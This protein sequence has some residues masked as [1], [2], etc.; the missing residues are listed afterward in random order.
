MT[1]PV[2]TF[3]EPTA[4]PTSAKSALTQYKDQ[5]A[6][7]P[8]SRFIGSI[9]WYSIAGGQERGVDG[10]R[11]TVPVRVHQDLLAAW[12]EEFEIDPAYLPPRIKKIDAFRA[13]T[14]QVRKREYPL[15]EGGTRFGQLRIDEVK[16]DPEQVIRHVVRI[17]RDERK[18]QLSMDH[19]ATI[20]FIRGGRTARGKRH[21]GD[22]VKWAIL[23]RVQGEDRVQVEALLDEFDERYEDLSNHLH[24]PALRGIVRNF[25][26]TSLNAISMKTSGGLYFVHKNKWPQVA[27]IQQL[28]RRLGPTCSLE[29]MPLVDNSDKRRMLT[30][31]FEVEIEEECQALLRLIAEANEKAPGGRINHRK[32]AELNAAFQE[33]STRSDEYSEMLD[34]TQGRAA[35]ALEVALNSVM[36]MASRVDYGGKK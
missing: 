15:D 33:I 16:S 23:S 1:R 5:L 13:A 8:A 22:H 31:A 34:V 20:K 14:T 18:E 25:L 36:E 19:L 4:A 11:T 3:Q 32:Y 29:D 35:D 26:V 2:P 7:L 9:V 28:V 24:S 27:A 17:V 6:G 12:F 30:E 10:K 21:S